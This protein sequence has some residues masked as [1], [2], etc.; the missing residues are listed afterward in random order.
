MTETVY[1]TAVNQQIIW[2][3]HLGDVV[4]KH[5]NNE[6]FIATPKWIGCDT[7]VDRG[8]AFCL[9]QLHRRE[10]MSGNAGPRVVHAS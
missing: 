7:E 9:F 5:E 3:T 2:S 8:F 1:D 4:F 10:D 6:I